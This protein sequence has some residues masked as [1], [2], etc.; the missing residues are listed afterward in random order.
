MKAPFDKAEPLVYRY[1]C[2]I[3]VAVCILP[4]LHNVCNERWLI[5]SFSSTI[6]LLHVGGC[7]E[8]FLAVLFWLMLTQKAQLRCELMSVS[9]IFV[10]ILLLVIIVF[11]FKS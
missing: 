4:C 1:R 7:L 3:T 2:V 9:V 6:H 10:L 8:L 5:L 11:K